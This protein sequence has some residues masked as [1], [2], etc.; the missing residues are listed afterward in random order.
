MEIVRCGHA[1]CISCVGNA[2]NVKVRGRKQ[3]NKDYQRCYSMGCSSTY[4]KL[5]AQ[6]L[7]EKIDDIFLMVSSS[8][9]KKTNVPWIFNAIHHNIEK[10]ILVDQN[11]LLKKKKKTKQNACHG[12]ILVDTKSNKMK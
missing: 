10:V 2:P 3:D 4:S 11:I 12:V 6:R 8:K 1:L 9:V 7:M 5:P